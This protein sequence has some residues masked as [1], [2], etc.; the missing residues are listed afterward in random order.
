MTQAHTF[1]HMQLA[2][3]TLLDSLPRLGWVA[4]PTPVQPMAALAAGLGLEWLGAKRD[5]TTQPLYGGCK[6]RKLDYLLASPPWRD[7]KKWISV[8]AIGSGHLVA[9]TAAAIELGRELEAHVFWEPPSAGVLDS[10]A[11]V[12]SGPTEIHYHTSRVTLALHHPSLLLATQRKGIPVIPPGGTIPVA[13]V[14]L[15]R[16]GVEL[17]MQVRAGMLPE[18]Q[19]VYVSLGSGGTAVGLALGFALGGLKTTV[20]AVAAVERHLASR[21][22][23]RKLMRALQ[24][25]LRAVGLPQLAEIEPTPVV[26][27]Y[28]QVGPGYGK[29]SRSSLD[30]VS[31]LRDEGILLEPIYTGKAM[32]ALLAD[33]ELAHRERRSLGRVLFWNTVRRVEALPHADDWQTHLPPSLRH[34]VRK[35]EAVVERPMSTVTRRRLLWATA[36]VATTALVVGRLTGYRGLQDWHGRELSEREALIIMAAAEAL[37]PPAPSPWQSWQPV[38]AGVDGYLASLPTGL[39][40]QVHMLL[41]FIEHATPLGGR[42]QRFSNLAPADRLQFL[43]ALRENGGVPAQAFAAL[44]ELC[45]LGYYQ[46]PASWQALGYTGPWVPAEPRPRRADYAAL[47]APVGSLP[48]SVQPLPRWQKQAAPKELPKAP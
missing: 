29:V 28:S 32:A 44:R 17:A 40:R 41:G 24:D 33:A 37:L 19:R 10:L 20:H 22:R 12:A 46:Q 16:A 27:D 8:G 4:D 23:L 42:V 48:R 14:G 11:Y 6:T 15:V 3:T 13:M 43:L 31:V 2:S 5:D 18:P 39:R 26:L 34:R 47:V 9:C 45:M 35:A 30:A 38:A 7:A 25:H 1:G 36:A 21:S